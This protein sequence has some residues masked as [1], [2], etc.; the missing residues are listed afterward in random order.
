MAA[1]VWLLLLVLVTEALQLCCCC[2]LRLHVLVCT[3]WWGCSCLFSLLLSHVVVLTVN[4]EPHKT[5]EL[6][7]DHANPP[8]V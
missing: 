6:Q 5:L 1:H 2:C 4:A 3:C 7:A 8:H